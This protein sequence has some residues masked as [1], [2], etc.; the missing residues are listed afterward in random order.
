MGFGV[1]AFHY[2]KPERRDELVQR[3]R[4]AAEVMRMVE[5]CVEALVWEVREG[6]ALVSTGTFA[7]EQA[8]ARAVE[9]VLEARVD[10]EYDQRELRPREV[11]FLVPPR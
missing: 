7:S 1:V 4:A 3:M 11:H 10:F 5:G 6:E 8:W 9:A 2:P